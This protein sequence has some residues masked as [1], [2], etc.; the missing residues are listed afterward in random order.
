MRNRSIIGEILKETLTEEGIK[1]WLRAANKLLDGKRPLDML[2]TKEGIE[3]V[4]DAAKSYV[5]G[6][7]V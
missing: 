6:N 4:I 3:R 2:N 7:Y 5:E 1:Q